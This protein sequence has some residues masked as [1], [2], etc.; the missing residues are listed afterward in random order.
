MKSPWN[1][2]ARLTSRGRS[3]EPREISIEHDADSQAN[4]TQEQ[5]VR[6][7][8]LSSTDPT[9]AFQDRENGSDELKEAASSDLTEHQDDNAQAVSTDA[10]VEEAPTPENQRI[11][12]LPPKESASLP[13]SK[14]SPKAP[15]IQA[16]AKKSGT[17]NI[18][19]FP[20]KANTDPGAQ[21]SAREA[22]F[23]E[24]A[25]LDDEIQQLRTLLAEKLHL[26]NLHL[27]KMLERFDRS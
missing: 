9:G 16:R 19:K 1:L 23:E 17:G 5:Q 4:D 25:D 3:A 12:E 2:F 24:V 6:G 22:F 15:Q 7:A 13:K 11:G 18:R 14:Q 27:R 8:Q 20:S 10:A 26:Q 21:L